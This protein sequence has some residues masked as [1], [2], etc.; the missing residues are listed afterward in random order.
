[1]KD[2]IRRIGNALRDALRPHGAERA[3][4]RLEIGADR[5]IDSAIERFPVLGKIDKLQPPEPREPNLLRETVDN[6]G[7]TEW[8]SKIAEQAERAAPPNYSGPSRRGH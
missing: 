2:F 1:M 7:G 4:R 6:M 3:M 5:V 8:I